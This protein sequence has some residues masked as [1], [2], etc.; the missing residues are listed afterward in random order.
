MSDNAKSLDRREDRYVHGGIKKNV[1]HE[2]TH[3]IVTVHCQSLQ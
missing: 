2:H 1:T 3:K